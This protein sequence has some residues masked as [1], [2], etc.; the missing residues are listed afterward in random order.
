MNAENAPPL[1]RR[2]LLRS[3]AAVGATAWLTPRGVVAEALATRGLRRGD[4]GPVQQF[5]RAA[6]AEPVRVH[7]VRGVSVLAGQGGRRHRPG[8][9]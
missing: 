9:P 8:G 7:R 5:R 2:Q 3:V 4:D 6:A 1:S